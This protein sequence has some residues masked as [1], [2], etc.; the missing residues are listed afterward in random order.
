MCKKIDPTCVEK[1][2]GFFLKG[3]EP[4]PIEMAILVALCECGKIY[5]AK[6]E[7]GTVWVVADREVEDVSDD[8]ADVFA[9]EVANGQTIG[10]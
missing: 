10:V 3:N 9:A 8:E 1:A 6:V 4:A 5:W 7:N 2:R